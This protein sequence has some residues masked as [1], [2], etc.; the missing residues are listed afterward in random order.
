MIERD[1]SFDIREQK[2]YDIQKK[3]ENILQKDF[4]LSTN[5]TKLGRSLIRI[6]YFDENVEKDLQKDNRI[7]ILYEPNKRIYVQIRGSL[8]DAQVGQIWDELKKDLEVIKEQEAKKEKMSN[9]DEIIKKIIN[10][11]KTKGYIIENIEAQN[12]I[13]NFQEKYH[14]LPKDEEIDSIVTGY[15]I[16]K[17]EEYLFQN[18]KESDIEAI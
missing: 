12:F 15:I 10:S 13:E 8:T 18:I 3:L 4:M 5:T 9:K 2:N 7:T 14:R 17:N 11:I 1:H 16:M 6:T